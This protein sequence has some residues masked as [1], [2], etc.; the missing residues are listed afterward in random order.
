M[1]LEYEHETCLSD[2][3]PS[4]AFE[5]VPT[6]L[7]ALL[8]RTAFALVSDDLSDRPI[9]QFTDLWLYTQINRKS[10]RR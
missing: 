8:L 4:F 3:P 10:L 2:P 9:R 1:L 7:E 6:P 5:R